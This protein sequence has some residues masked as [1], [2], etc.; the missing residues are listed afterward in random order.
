MVWKM[1]S[2]SDDSIGEEQGVSPKPNTTSGDRELDMSQLNWG[3][4]LYS[5][6]ILI[7]PIQVHHFFA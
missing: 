6:L 4:L 7:I 3:L 1:W 5:K 2:T